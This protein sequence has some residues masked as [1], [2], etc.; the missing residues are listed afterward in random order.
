VALTPEEIALDTNRLVDLLRGDRE[1]AYRLDCSARVYIPLFVFAEITAGFLGGNAQI[2]NQATLQRFLR[3]PTAEILLPDLETAEHFARLF[4][5][6][7]RAG[8][9]IPVYDLWIAALCVQH[10]LTLITRDRHFESIP[11]LLTA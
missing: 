2:R 9:P 5:Q 7:R 4:V 1:L 11:Q 6:L 8:Q 3:Q 10:R